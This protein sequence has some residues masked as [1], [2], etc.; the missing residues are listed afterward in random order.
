MNIFSPVLQLAHGA[1]GTM[2][3]QEGQTA[4]DLATAEDVRA[5]LQYAMPP[6]STTTTTPNPT[7]FPA[8]LLYHMYIDCASNDLDMNSIDII[9][10]LSTAGPRRRRHNEEPRRPDRPRSGHGR[11]RTRPI[12]RR[13]ASRNHNQHPFTKPHFISRHAR[14]NRKSV[15]HGASVAH[16]CVRKWRRGI[17]E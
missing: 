1:D 15:G 8:T 13:N 10:S 16:W 4:L 2:K 17:W 7:S 3:N 9:F 11:R 5:L 12:T 14:W 6:G